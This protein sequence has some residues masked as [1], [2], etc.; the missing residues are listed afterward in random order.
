MKSG[1]GA[2]DT[3]DFVARLITFMGGRKPAAP[4]RLDDEDED[5]GSEFD[6]G[7]APLNWERLG[8][9]VLARSRRV[10]AMDFM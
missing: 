5:D 6:G 9:R 2:F 4:S 8:R 7:D 3:D 10:P 1:S